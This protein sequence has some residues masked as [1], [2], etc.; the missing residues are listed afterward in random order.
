MGFS[1][2]NFFL[3][4][5]ALRKLRDLKCY[6]AHLEQE[7]HQDLELAMVGT[8]VS[9]LVDLVTAGVHEGS[10]WASSL[11][12]PASKEEATMQEAPLPMGASEAIAGPSGASQLP[13]LLQG[14]LHPLPHPSACTSCWILQASQP[15]RLG[16]NVHL[17][18]VQKAYLQLGLCGVPLPSGVSRGLSCLCPMWDEL[19][20]SL[21]VPS[22]WQGNP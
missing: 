14:D 20:R 10:Q 18:A 19:F 8:P 17:Q 16:Q 22:P 2:I 4:L 3:S 7:G 21:K 1:L 11:L 13:V 12:G 9:W 6:A 5:Q 15:E